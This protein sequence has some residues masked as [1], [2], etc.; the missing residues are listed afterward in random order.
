MKALL[1]TA[2][3]ARYVVGSMSAVMFAVSSGSGF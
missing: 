3:H 1:K 2:K